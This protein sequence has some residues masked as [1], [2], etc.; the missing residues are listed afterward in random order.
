MENN[1]K[2]FVYLVTPELKTTKVKKLLRFLR[3]IPKRKEN[4]I[5]LYCNYTGGHINLW[6][7]WGFSTLRVLEYTI[8]YNDGKSDTIIYTK[9]RGDFGMVPTWDQTDPL[10]KPQQDHS[11]SY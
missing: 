1:I 9:K 10:K 4:R 8:V 11:Q 6:E 2:H 3:L 5:T 7:G